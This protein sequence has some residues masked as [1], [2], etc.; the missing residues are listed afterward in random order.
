MNGA[1]VAENQRAFQIGRW[2]MTDPEAVA[3][4][5]APVEAIRPDPITYRADFLVDYQDQAYAQRFRDLVATAPEDLR[6]LARLPLS[7]KGYGLVKDKAAEAAAIRRAELLAA[8]ADGGT[9]MA[10]AAE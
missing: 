1:K 8:F 3:R 5:T 7:V 4:A 6:E 9:P 2:A 10:H